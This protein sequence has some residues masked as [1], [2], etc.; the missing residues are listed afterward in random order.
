MALKYLKDTEVDI[1]NV[2]IITGNFNIRD[3]SWDLNFPY[4]SHHSNILSK[5]VDSFQ[6][7][8]SRPT[9]QVPT[10]YF[11][12]Q[13]NSNFVI[14]LMFLRPGFLEHNNHTIHLNW[15]LTSDHAPLTVN[16]SI[17]KEHIQ[18]RK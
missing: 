6:L 3:S 17:F 13:Q 12:N 1:S 10:R 11:D 4:H 5:I 9:E 18:T 14:D 16:I 15:R 2:L 8:L 7:E